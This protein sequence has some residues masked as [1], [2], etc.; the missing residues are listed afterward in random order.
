[1]SGIFRRKYLWKTS[2]AFHCLLGHTFLRQENP[3]NHGLHSC[4]QSDHAT[5]KEDISK[6]KALWKQKGTALQGPC[7][8]CTSAS[9]YHLLDFEGASSQLLIK[10]K[11]PANF[12]QMECIHNLPSG[13]TAVKTLHFTN[14]FKEITIGPR[15]PEPNDFY[16]INKL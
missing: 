1:M 15:F 10:G 6:T 2:L 8:S 9:L 7:L 4:F 11:T 16:I 14:Y 12:L 3:N 5:D 13:R